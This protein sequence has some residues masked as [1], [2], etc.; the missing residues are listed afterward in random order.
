MVRATTAVFLAGVTLSY[1]V[2]IHHAYQ[3][4]HS[5][6]SLGL[7][8]AERIHVTDGEARQYRWLASNINKY[9]DVFFSEPGIPSLNFWT[10]KE[11]FTMFDYETW[12]LYITPNQQSDVQAALAEHPDACVVYNPDLVQFW[13]KTKAELNAMPLA[14]YIN[15]NFT[16]LTE[17]NHYYL[18]VRNGRAPD[19]MKASH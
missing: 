5:M 7:S 9:C 2:L 10:A 13:Q 4:Y 8:G 17:M 14:A 11:P 18:L 6:E 1:L 19:L 16:V 3:Q 15:N 12:I